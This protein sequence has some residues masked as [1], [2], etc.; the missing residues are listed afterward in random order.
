[1][2]RC[3]SVQGSTDA[4]RPEASDSLEPEL[5]VVMSWVPWMWVLGIK[6]GPLET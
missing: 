1:M 3:E 6:F 2:V 4:Q 5:K